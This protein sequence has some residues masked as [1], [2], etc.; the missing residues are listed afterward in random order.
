MSS[1]PSSAYRGVPYPSVN[2]VNYAASQARA[3]G[4]SLASSALSSALAFENPFNDAKMIIMGLIVL[5]LI[6]YF[7]LKDTTIGKI[8][9]FPFYILGKLIGLIEKIF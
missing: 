6:Y 9:G 8:I 3:K 5:F 1:F 2:P 7:F 4:S